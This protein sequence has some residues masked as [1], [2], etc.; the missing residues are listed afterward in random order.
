MPFIAATVDSREPIT[1]TGLHFT[2]P[3]NVA[4]LETGDFLGICGDGTI[5]LV[6][7]KAVGDLL[8]SIAD[9]RLFDQCRRLRAATQWCYL[10]IVGSLQPALNGK[11]LADGRQYDW[12]WARVQGA[13]LTVQELGVLILYCASDL[14]YVATLDRLA[15]RSR[16]DVRIAPHRAGIPLTPGECVLTGLPGI[17]EHLAQR[18]LVYCPSPAWALAMLTDVSL[19]ANVP[20]IGPGIRAGVRRALGLPDDMSMSVMMNDNEQPALMP[21]I[22]AAG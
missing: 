17:G 18:I 16:G 19:P 15:E 4:M 14:D 3:T 22:E 10:V 7:R 20:G 8:N 1:I 12:D 2:A 9:G 11:T 5:I 13:L 21:A 6:E